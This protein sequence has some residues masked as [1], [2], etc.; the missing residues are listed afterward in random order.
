M[1]NKKTT[2]GKDGKLSSKLKQRMDKAIMERNLIL[3]EVGDEYPNAEW[4]LNEDM[5]HLLTDK[6]HDMGNG[7]KAMQDRS[8]AHGLIINA[9]G[10]G[11]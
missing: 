9:S 3:A 4:Y 1:A 7:D 5:L 6:S 8:I 10:G 11:W 2:T